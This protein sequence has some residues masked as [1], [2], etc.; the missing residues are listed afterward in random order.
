MNLAMGYEC[1][2]SPDIVLIN[3]DY[4]IKLFTGI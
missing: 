2:K 1:V 4:I 3:D